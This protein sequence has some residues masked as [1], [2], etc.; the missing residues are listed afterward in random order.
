M[1][2]QDANAALS[3]ERFFEF[4]LL[5]LVVSGYLAIAGS[6]YLDILTLAL[7][8]AGLILRGLIVSGVLPVEIPR[9]AVTAAAVIYA[10]FLP[11]DYYLSS[12]K[13]LETAV[14]L[15]FFLAVAQILTART[16]RDY[17]CTALI[18][19]AELVAAAVLSVNPNFFVFLAIY[20]LCAIAAL[21]SGEIRRAIGKSQVVA[22][23]GQR[24]FHPR[25]AALTASAAL[26]I[27]ALTAGLFFLLPRTAYAAF[28]SLVSHRI[29]LPGFSNLVTLGKV[30]EIRSDSR[31]VMHV[32]SSRPGMLSGLKW[33]G[34]ALTHFDGKHWTNPGLR[35]TAV[36]V[37]DR[38]L[39]LGGA[40]EGSQP[41]RYISYEV[42]LDAVDTNTLFFAGVPQV[43]RMNTSALD[44]TDTGSFRLRERMPEGFRY[45]ADSV[46][47]DAPESSPAA[48]PPPVL[49]PEARRRNLQLPIH[50]DP[51]VAALARAM[52]QDSGNSDLERARA[53]EARLRSGYRY[54]LE[55]PRRE[56]ADPLADF[57]FVRREGYCE[58]FASA[59]AVML[60]TLGIPAR[61]ATGFQSGEF[62]DITGRWVIRAADAHAWVEAWIPG[63][64]WTT[65]DPTPPDPNGR[66][67]GLLAKFDLY[68]DAASTF[69]REWVVN[70]DP[71]RQGSL[72]DRLQQR[73]GR[74]GWRW[75][76][77]AW[78][79]LKEGPPAFD[80]LWGKWI[81]LY[82]GGLGLLI[83]G[84]IKVP[85]AVRRLRMRRR[86]EQAR[87]GCASAIDAT[88]LYQ[89]MLQVVKQRGYQKPSWFTP[90]EFAASLHRTEF[91]GRVTEFTA[92]Y[93]ELRFGGRREAAQRLT[94]LLDDLERQER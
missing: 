60:R 81:A 73:A 79:A 55:M 77:A 20:L 62:N 94:M 70:Y 6:G 29:Y 45:Q 80:P 76:S 72:A 46:L 32:T 83:G 36:D 87:R 40:Q 51:H 11:F 54:S 27:L 26:G 43:V 41:V 3:V 25:L 49:D 31:P 37:S 48:Y 30:G 90:A 91:G 71:R 34:G 56:P 33:R 93:N 85:S 5:G 28:S 69:W 18:S 53:I 86:V 88:L 44:G 19:F 4:A 21:S 89:R 66:R 1:A 47:E 92:A 58:H 2:R 15:L 13:V 7:T 57:L 39:D 17:F 24:G 68:L 63:R 23:A 64:G 38:R 74:Y 35:W 52:T 50:L 67:F 84:G 22:R 42:E 16:S 82:G 9:R 10:V 59:M 12:R 75:A 78:L 8:A 65:F 61:L 14:H